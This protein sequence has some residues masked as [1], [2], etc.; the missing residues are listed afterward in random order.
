[1][2]SEGE[3]K[4]T[5]SKYAEDDEILRVPIAL[6]MVKLLQNLPKGALERYLPGFVVGIFLHK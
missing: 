2:K 5:K 1:M 6:A 4:L 3:H